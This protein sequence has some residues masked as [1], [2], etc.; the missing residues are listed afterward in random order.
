MKCLRNSFFILLMALTSINLSAQIRPPLIDNWKTVGTAELNFLWFDVYQAELRTSNGSF[1]GFNSPMQLALTYKRDISAEQLLEETG[2][3]LKGS[4][5]EQQRREWLSLLNTI[6]PDVT[7][8]DT[9]I[10]QMDSNGEGH[11]F[12]NNNWIGSVA[13]PDFGMSFVK[14]WLSDN[15]AYPELAQRLRGELP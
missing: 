14:I 12:F 8:G 2:K 11:F 9:L 7:K 6:W 5:N 4:A 13:S 3:Q 1:Q 15:S 10:F